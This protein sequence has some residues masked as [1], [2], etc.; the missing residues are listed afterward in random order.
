MTEDFLA[1][2]EELLSYS[3]Q[4]W[5]LGAGASHDA[6]LPLVAGLTQRVL[7]KLDRRPFATPR[8]DGV[9]MGQVVQSLRAD[10]GASATIEQI[11]DHLAD[12]LSMAR[13]SSHGATWLRIMTDSENSGLGS[14]QTQFTSDELGAIRSSALEVIRDTIRWGYVHPA[15]PTCITEGSPER[16]IIRINHHLEFVRVIFDQLRAGRQLRIPPVEFFTTNYD[17]LIEDALAL[18]GVA[19]RDG[20]RGGAVAYW[21]YNS[22]TDLEPTSGAGGGR[23][24]LRAS[25]TKLHGS[26]DWVRTNGRIVRRRLSDGYPCGDDELLIYP[27]ASKFELAQR[28]PFDS[29]FTIFRSSLNRPAPRV[30]FACGYGFGDDHIDDEIGDALGRAGSQFTLVAFRQNR[31]GKPAKWQA[32]SFGERVYTITMHGVWRGAEGPFLTPAPGETR[33]W[34]TFAGMTSFLRSPRGSQ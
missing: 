7:N 4:M 18:S 23:A 12:H 20:F 22:L 24:I 8:A 29:L 6:K 28:E 3:N 26:I 9:T 33:D 31:D 17:T 32:E 21:D 14:T 25:L 34:W 2:F 11:L 15:D 19:Y 27:Q 10:I 1:N 5:L 30:L 13:R 16:P